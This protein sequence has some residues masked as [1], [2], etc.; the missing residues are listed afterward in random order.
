MFWGYLHN[1]CI[2]PIHN[3]SYQIVFSFFMLPS[4]VTPKLRNKRVSNINFKVIMTCLVRLLHLNIK[5]IR[6]VIT[7]PPSFHAWL[8]YYTSYIKYNIVYHTTTRFPRLVRLL[9]LKYKK[10][11]CDYHTNGR[12]PCLTRLRW[13][14]YIHKR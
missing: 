13:L 2:T 14:K 1:S 4:L 9:C 10:Y 3:L 6:V 5:N 7:P 12:F 8:G 11:K